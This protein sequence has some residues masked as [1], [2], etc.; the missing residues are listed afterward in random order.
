MIRSYTVLLLA[1]CLMAASPAWAEEASTPF[2]RTMDIAELSPEEARLWHLSEEADRALRKSG[3]LLGDKAVD[4]YLQG[5]LDRLYP[6]FHGNLRIRAVRDPSLN[7]FALPNG[8]LYI[9]TGLI[10]RLQ[11]E[12]QLAA[13]LSHEGAHFVGRHGYR[14]SSAARSATAA[15][16]VIQILGVPI[17]GEVIALSSISGYSKEHEGEADDIGFQ[18]L[19]K[20]G[21]DPREGARIFEYL[22]A[23]VKAADIQ[24][25]F[26][27][28]SHPKLAERLENYTRLAALRPAGG[29]TGGQ[30]FMDTTGPLRVQ[31]LE[32]D[33]SAGRYRSVIL[34][35]ED[36]QRRHGYPLYVDYYLGEAYRLRDGEGDRANAEQSYLKAALVAPGFAPTDRGLGLLY[37]KAGDPVRARRHFEQYLAKAPAA[38]DRAFIELYLDQMKQETK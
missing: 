17:V 18:R 33:L 38:R 24:E 1:G 22:M 9:H 29:E 27:F 12:A 7:A 23:E 3:S 21:Y 5:V 8:S 13:V 36:P 25:P 4:A 30:R 6:E 35:L 28:S 14:H 2:E 26:F 16:T 10:A 20:A 34:I 19:V 11:N 32:A 31:A 37:M 15:M